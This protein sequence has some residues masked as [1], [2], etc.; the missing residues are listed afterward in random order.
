M[1]RLVQIIFL[2][3]KVTLTLDFRNRAKNHVIWAARSGVMAT[4][5]ARAK[6]MKFAGNV[7]LFSLP[8]KMSQGHIQ[9]ITIVKPGTPRKSG[10]IIKKRPKGGK[11][12]RGFS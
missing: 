2:E 12:W 4:F 7:N 6:W 11:G 1:K 9:N 3:S 10:F 5:I 8:G